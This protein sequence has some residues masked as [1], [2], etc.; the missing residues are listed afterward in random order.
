VTTEDREHDVVVYG[1]TGFVGKLTAAYLAKQ[2]P[3]PRI[4]L[5]GR[6]HSKLVAVRESLGA[7]AAQWPLIE[8]DASDESSVAALA[9]STRAVATTM[10]T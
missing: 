9:A 3:G 2:P 4:A 6:N 10:R 8:A 1:A 7:A 5:A